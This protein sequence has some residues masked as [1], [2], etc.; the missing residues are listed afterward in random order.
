MGSGKN[1]ECLSRECL[2]NEPSS[3]EA[4]LSREWVLIFGFAPLRGAPVFKCCLTTFLS[5][6][7]LSRTQSGP[8]L[9]HLCGRRLVRFSDICR[10]RY[11]L[12]AVSGPGC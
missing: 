7:Y 11:T 2:S 4:A 6:W 10:Q 1:S 12:R 8:L 5:L 3:I 9:G